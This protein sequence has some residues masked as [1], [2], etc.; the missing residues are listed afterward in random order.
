MKI[1]T[2]IEYMKAYSEWR[3]ILMCGYDNLKET[4]DQLYSEIKEY[5]LIHPDYPEDD[6]IPWWTS[7]E[8]LKL[9]RSK[10]ES[11]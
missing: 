4:T 6:K 3:H 8:G 10:K 2:E 5:Q 7:P 1:N 11:I 9:F